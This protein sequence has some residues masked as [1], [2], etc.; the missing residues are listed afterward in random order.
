MLKNKLIVAGAIFASC[1]AIFTVWYFP[2]Q[3]LDDLK[4]V[5]YEGKTLFTDE[6]EYLEF[7]KL[8]ASNDIDIQ[9]IYEVQSDNPLIMYKFRT[10][11]QIDFEYAEGN[12]KYRGDLG[13]NIAMGI[14]FTVLIIGMLSVII[15]NNYHPN[16]D[17]D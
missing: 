1:I 7:K 9:S 17:L 15:F 2:M 3:E 10:D 11:E 4:Y 14:G 8:L 13:T 6:N 5:E 16:L 12:K